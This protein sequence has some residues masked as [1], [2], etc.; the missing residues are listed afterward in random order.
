MSRRTQRRNRRRRRSRRRRS[1]RR[2]SRRRGGNARYSSNN[3]GNQAK[4]AQA[5]QRRKKM[6][7]NVLGRAP[8]K[9]PPPPPGART[10]SLRGRYSSNNVGNQAKKAQANQRRKKKGLNV[11][12]RVPRKAAPRRTARARPSWRET[13]AIGS[14]RKLAKYYGN[15]RSQT[16]LGNVQAKGNAAWGAAGATSA[17]RRSAWDARKKKEL[18]V[19]K[20]AANTAA[21]KVVAVTKAAANQAAKQVTCPSHCVPTATAGG[22][23]RRRRR[24]RR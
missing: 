7:L 10:A 11:L 4:K 1:R 19:G 9:A 23:R 12:G 8:R 13:A 20:K 5:N 6:G 3:V 18:N 14:E 16:K 2:R 22:R 17:F 15:N 21:T 24:T